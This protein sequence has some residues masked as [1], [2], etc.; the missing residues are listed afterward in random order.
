[1]HR[2]VKKLKMNSM[3]KDVLSGSFLESALLIKNCIE[4]IKSIKRWSENIKKDYEMKIE[5]IHFNQLVEWKFEKRTKTLYHSTGKFF[6][7]EGIR[8][9]TNFYSIKEWDQPIIVQPEIGILGIITKKFN[10]VRYFLMQAKIEPGNINSVQ[11]S[12]TVQATRSNYTRVHLGEEP[13]FLEYF[14]NK[15]KSKILIDRLQS[16]QGARFLKKRN[17]NMIVEI[18]DDIKVPNDFCWMTLGQ[19]KELLK[20]DNFVNMDSRSVISC[21]Q[22]IDL[23]IRQMINQIVLHDSSSINI[24]SYELTGF[25]KDI[26]CSYTE[27]QRAVNSKNDL[28]N[29]F[30]E[31][32]ANYNCSI[33]K[34][35]L[36]DTKNWEIKSDEIKHISNSFFSIIA[37]SVKAKNREV[38]KWTQP[39][40]WQKSIG[41]VGFLCK[42][43]NGVL[44]FLIRAKVESGYFDILEMSPT[45]TTSDINYRISKNNSPHFVNYFIEP[46]SDK[47]HYSVLLS[48]E[49]GRFFN[50]QNKYMIVEIDYSESPKIPENYI[51][52]TLGQLMDFIQYDNY[53]SIEVRTLFSLMNFR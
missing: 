48:E 11:L 14:I 49:G 16:E 37:V 31:M 32:K 45:V 35:P 44:H 18:D 40:I 17:R 12:P 41:L 15:S 4:S 53:V 29:W 33:K 27:K 7:I 38:S 51:W 36:D 42:K 28:I 30:T 1:M 19:I 46:I 43:I 22:F 9:K 6:R 47:V 24:C 20:I 25:N 50:Y 26:F 2:N 13:K 10:G 34:I 8:V 3:D 23:E 39:L 52:M 21:I 5:R